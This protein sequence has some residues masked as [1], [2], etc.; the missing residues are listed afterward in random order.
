MAQ[1]PALAI[2]SPRE[3]PEKAIKTAARSGEPIA[4]AIKIACINKSFPKQG[5]DPDPP[6]MARCGIIIQ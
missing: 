5:R 3:E 4:T 2:L 6:R 1:I